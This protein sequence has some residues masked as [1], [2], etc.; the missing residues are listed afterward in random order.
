MKMAKLSKR[1]K[2][3]SSLIRPDEIYSLQ[4]AID[5]LKEVPSVKFDQSLEISLKLGVDPRKTDQSVRGTVSLPHGT[6]K[7]MRV[8]VFAKGDKALEATE[9]GAEFVG[10]DEYFEKVR[11]G[12]TDFDAVV[13][14]PDMMREVGKLGKILGPRNL[15][16]SPKAGSVTNQVGDAVTKIKAG[17][18][19]FKLDASALINGLSGKL[20]FNN[21]AL[22]EN[23]RSF[24]RA[25]L[26]AKPA[27]AKGQFMK[28]L[29]IS[30]TMGPG[31]S[32]DLKELAASI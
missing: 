9:A 26:R 5:L 19:E 18:V 16:P 15:M 31:I 29:T 22:V 25:V 7:I 4:S 24:I 17:R 13:A 12:W 2:T 10:F 30:S 1:M 8:L 23:V 20:S 21:Q 27:A 11:G 28:H 3:I 32:V 14:T 6:G